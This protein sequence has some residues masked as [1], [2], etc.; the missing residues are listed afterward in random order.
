MIMIRIDRLT[1]SLRGI[2]GVDGHRLAERLGRD[3]ARIDVSAL[4]ASD[5]VPRIRLDLRAASTESE[6]SLSRQIADALVRA[7]AGRA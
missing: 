4:G 2:G 6:D 7:I 1:L 3:L 5:P